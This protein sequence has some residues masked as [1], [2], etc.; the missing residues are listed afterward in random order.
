MMTLSL[1]QVSCGLWSSCFYLFFV[2]K[3]VECLK[4]F[5]GNDISVVCHE[6]LLLMLW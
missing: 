5:A 3:V 6:Y 4:P 2:Y 1:R